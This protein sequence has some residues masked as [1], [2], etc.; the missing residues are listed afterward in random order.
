[1]RKALTALVA[2]GLAIGL[3]SAAGAASASGLELRFQLTSHQPATA[4]G[5]TPHI[6]YPDNGP[7]GKPKPVS[8][9]VYKFPLGTTIDEAAVPTCM[10]SNAELE[11]L[12]SDACP[13]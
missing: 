6:V 1:M 13:A 8:K 11:L 2:V 9:G 3:G 4:T 10:A 12:G 5:A 7:G